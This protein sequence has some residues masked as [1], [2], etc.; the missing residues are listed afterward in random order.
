[1]QNTNQSFIKVA[2]LLVNDLD[3][4][5]LGYVVGLGL[6][7]PELKILFQSDIRLLRYQMPKSGK[8]TSLATNFFLFSTFFLNPVANIAANYICIK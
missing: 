4:L 6:Q 8:S 5:I 1:M 7:N 3:F 2:W